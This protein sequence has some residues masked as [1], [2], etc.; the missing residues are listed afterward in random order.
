MDALISFLN[1]RCDDLAR[2]APYTHHIN[3]ATVLFRIGE[4]PDLS[5]CNCFE[6]E[7]LLADVDAKRKIIAL[8]STPDGG[9]GCT[10][11]GRAVLRLLALPNARHRDY[12]DEWQS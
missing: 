11:A 10:D 7:R 2:Q 4:D 8:F 3:C 6:T 5:L 9:D 1:A 12:R